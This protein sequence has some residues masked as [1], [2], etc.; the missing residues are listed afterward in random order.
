MKFGV[1]EE[2]NKVK[3]VKTFDQFQFL[4]FEDCLASEKNEKEPKSHEI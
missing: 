1:N 2:K 3:M 4:G